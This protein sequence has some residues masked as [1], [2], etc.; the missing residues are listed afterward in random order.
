LPDV[1]CSFRGG[2]GTPYSCEDERIPG[3]VYVPVG[4]FGDPELFEPEMHD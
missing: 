2:C 4:V 1:R 3:E